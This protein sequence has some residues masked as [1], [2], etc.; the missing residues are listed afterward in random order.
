MEWATIKNNLVHLYAHMSGPF[1]EAIPGDHGFHCGG[2]NMEL[3]LAV[4][5]VS[6]KL[7]L[8]VPA[9]PEFNVDDENFVPKLSAVGGEMIEY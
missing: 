3:A 8:L 6:S 1:H 9:F 2:K 4:A 7:Q 5:L